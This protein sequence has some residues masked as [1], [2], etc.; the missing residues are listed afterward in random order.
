MSLSDFVNGF[1][2]GQKGFGEVISSIVNLI[3]LLLVYILGIGLTYI[4]ARFAKNKFLALSPDNEKKTYW[5]D[6]N[7]TKKPMEEYCRQF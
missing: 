7:L 2:K 4:V 1:K 6:L 5:E 3:L